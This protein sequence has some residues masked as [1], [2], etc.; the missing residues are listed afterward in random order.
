MAESGTKDAP[1]RKNDPNKMAARVA[2]DP[3]VPSDKPQDYYDTI[4]QRFAEER[5]VRLKYR[6]EGLSQYTSELEG[7]LAK[8]EVD[9]YAE[10][11][12]EREPITDHVECL[13]IGG[14]FSALLTAARLRERGVESIRIVER[15]SDVGGTW[16]WNRYPGAAC[17]VSAYDY[18]PLLDELGYVPNSFF[19]KGPEIYA[20][21]QAIAKKYDLYDLAV[22]QTT[23]TAT[24]WDEKEKIWRLETDR[25]DKLTARF[26]IVANGTLAKPKL[27]RIKGME[28]FEGHSFH[29][30]RFDYDYCGGDL[31]NLKDKVVGVIGT[32]ASAVQIIP[33]V[34]KAAKALHV[35]QRTP[36][37]I[38]IRDDIPTDPDW[39]SSLKPG[40]QV[41]RLKRHVLNTKADPEKRREIE[42]LP[43]EERIK[44]Y[45]N[46]NI[47]HQMR[48]HAR[49]DS[50]VEDK[51]TAEALK[52]WYMHRCKRPCYDDEYLPA[53]NRPN[54][55][56]V[57]TKGQGVTEI[58]K[59][60]VVFEGKEYPVDVLIYATG[61]E[62]Q[63]TGIYND[64]RGENNLELNEKYSE[65]M[66]TVFGVHSAGYPNMFIMGGYQASFQFNVTF[67]LQTQGFHIAEC[68]KY[69]RENGH[70]TIDAKPETEQWWVDEVIKFRGTTDRNKECTPGYYNF[71]GQENRRQDGNYNGGMYQYAEHLQTAKDKLPEYFKFD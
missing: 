20:H 71:E 43:R 21:C 49:V 52:P 17:D 22:F 38:D 37:A 55:H 50:I 53:F 40:W 6:P 34:G 58:N 9:P 27:S 31:S 54:V 24:H 59:R 47:E 48:I 14:G 67:M 45:E 46:Q 12:T 56:L 2:F 32:G 19:A 42:K 18:L 39:A 4:K 26:V 65:G 7:D 11:Q 70:T 69:T 16:Y 36:S 66:R 57:D 51:A 62:V 10:E 13:F 29:S 25:G 8:Y 35:F 64:I 63:V 68:I 3:T 60:G 15:G 30:S 5:D 1:A 61:F 33:R 23:V 44:R 41:E 28:T